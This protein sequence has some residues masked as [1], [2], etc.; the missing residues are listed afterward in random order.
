M[1]VAVSAQSFAEELSS[2]SE[3]AAAAKKSEPEFDPLPPLAKPW[4]RITA[5]KSRE[6]VWVN[7]KTKQVA[8]EGYVCLTKGYLELFACVVNTKEHESVVALE[9]K[10]KTLHFALLAIGAKH[11]SPAKWSKFGEYTPASGQTID[12][13]VEWMK[14]G[15]PTR[16]RAQEWIRDLKTKKAMAHDWVFG[17]SRLWTDPETKKSYYSADDG[18][19][20]CVSNFPVAMLD[21]PIES[22]IAN[23]ELAFEALT[24]KIP[25][26]K[27]PV[28]VYLVPKKGEKEK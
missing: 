28:R 25:I 11:G 24:E 4:T 19:V 8:V 14:D 3:V 16:T 17:G 12:V 15:K 22:S 27:T 10:A 9:S 20:I 2:P 13:L 7:S 5:P 18:E 1:T 21:L 23:E 6:K 26:R